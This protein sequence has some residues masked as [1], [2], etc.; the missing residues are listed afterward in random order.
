MEVFGGQII[1]LEKS[2]EKGMLNA[3]QIKNYL[4]KASKATCKIIISKNIFGSGFFCLIPYLEKSNSLLHALI[5]CY[6]VLDNI[7]NENKI[8]I[9]INEEHKFISLEQRKFWIN[10]ELDFICIEIKE[11]QELIAFILLIIIIVIIII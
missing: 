4:D 2:D 11:K 10:K 5:T 6:H 3:D 7:L 9:I 8:E 1:Q